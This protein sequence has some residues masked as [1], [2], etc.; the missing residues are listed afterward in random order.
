MKK[1]ISILSLVVFLFNVGGYYV[2]FWALRIN[3]NVQLEKRLDHEEYAEDETYEFKIPLSIPY[4]IQQ[5]DFNRAR[6][7]FEKDGEIYTLVKQKL[8]NDTLHLICIRN[9]KKKHLRKALFEYARV[10]HDTGSAMTDNGARSLPKFI[11]DFNGNSLLTFDTSDSWFL[12]VTHAFVSFDI[13]EMK[14]DIISPP[15]DILS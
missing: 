9:N 1:A 6:G 15:P 14:Y 3:A 2:L 8:E 10:S 4:P 11:K 13:L 5:K 12:Q 7:E